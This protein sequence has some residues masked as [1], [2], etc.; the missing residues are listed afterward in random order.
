MMHFLSLVGEK[1]KTIRS[2][3]PD[4]PEHSGLR[5]N[6][7]IDAGCLPSIETPIS[8][9]VCDRLILISTY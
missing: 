4:L 3:P 2:C 1:N 7:F 8:S 6:W 9:H 5:T